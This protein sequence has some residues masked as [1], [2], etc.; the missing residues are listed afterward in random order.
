MNQP[1]LNKVATVLQGKGKPKDIGQLVQ[2]EIEA[3]TQQV[4][5]TATTE[6]NEF[7]AL[8][9]ATH[10]AVT[11]G[12]SDLPRAIDLVLDAMSEPYSRCF[13]ITTV[14]ERLWAIEDDE[15]YTRLANVMFNDATVV[16][17]DRHYSLSQK[18]FIWNAVADLYLR[19]GNQEKTDA[20]RRKAVELAVAGQSSDN[21][22]Q[23]ITECRAI[24]GNII[25]I[26]I[27]TH[28]FVDAL[29]IAKQ[30]D[31]KLRD[32]WVNA[33]NILVEVYPK[34]RQ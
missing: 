6:R 11:G 25:D 34:N 4:K 28:Q 13:T 5:N 33:L 20:A 21:N 26:L 31:G 30:W 16:E 1:S 2:H 15:E 10:L 9:L 32:Y 24:L 8:N 18:A 3:A 7:G 22:P 29:E 23:D 17:D 27:S 19:I 14:C 12:L